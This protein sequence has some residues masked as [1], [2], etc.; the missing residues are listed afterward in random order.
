M[1]NVRTETTH[2]NCHCLFFEFPQVTRQLECIQR[3]F[4][5]N[6]LNGQPLGQLSETGLFLVLCRTNLNNRSITANLDRNRFTAV[7]INTQDT[8]T[9][10]MLGL[11]IHR[12]FHQRMEIL[13][14]HIHHTVPLLLAFCHLIK[15]LFHTGCEVV[16]HN[17]REVIH[18]EVID[19]N[20]HIG[21]QELRFFVTR[22]FRL[23]SLSDLVIFQFQYIVRT[24]HP[25]L[26]TSFHITSLLNGR[27]SRRIS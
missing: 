12:L 1:T 5:C 13:I 22:H 11:G 19:H 9:H 27:D 18:Q 14:E 2:T 23:S 16:I 6:G 4:Q 20:T 26:T 15:F 3:F 8:F 21:R 10:T 24:L 17:V 7:R 25:F